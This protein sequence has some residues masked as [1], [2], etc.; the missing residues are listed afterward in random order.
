MEV[1]GGWGYGVTKPSVHLAWEGV[2]PSQVHAI[3]SLLSLSWRVCSCRCLA[4]LHCP[5]I[6][7]LTPFSSMLLVASL[8]FLH[9]VLFFEV[10]NS[11]LTA[12]L[13]SYYAH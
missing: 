3:K 5:L 7:Y 4:P 12:K 6:L 10:I 9:Y 13:T 11:I 8:S 1:L 2:S